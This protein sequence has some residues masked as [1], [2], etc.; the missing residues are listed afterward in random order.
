L[1]DAY[2]SAYER[3]VLPE[4]PDPELQSLVAECRELLDGVMA[5][6]AAIAS[7]IDWAAKRAMLEQFMEAEQLPWHDAS[8][9]SFD[10]EYSNLEPQDGL[11]YA[12]A[13][14]GAVEPEPSAVELVERLEAH[15]EPTRALARGLAVS[16]FASDLRGVSWGWLAF[17]GQNGPIQVELRPDRDYDAQL[18]DAP[19]VESFVRAIRGNQ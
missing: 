4:E 19:D 2:L 3:C 5:H 6:D 9:R 12:L 11:Y 15:T 16:R 1:L 10:L 7:R 13:Q 8:L 14:M 18:A 17:E